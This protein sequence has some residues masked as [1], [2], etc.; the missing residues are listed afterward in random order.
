MID[1]TTGGEIPRE[2]INLTPK[3]LLNGFPKAGL[4]FA[5]LMLRPVAAEMPAGQMHARPFVGTFAGHS[6]TTEWTDVPRFMYHVS[7]LQPGRYFYSHIGHSD[8]IEAF[9]YYLGAS[10]L[11]CS[12]D[13]RD[14]AVS[15]AHH[16]TADNEAWSHPDKDLYRD[17][18][19]FDEAL[20]A[21]IVGID[22]YPGVVERWEAYAG[23]WEADWVYQ[24]R[25]EDAI[26]DPFRVARAI[27]TYGIDRMATLFGYDLKGEGPKL[28]R[29]AE[30]MVESAGQREKSLT[31]RKGQV[32]GWRDAFTEK[33]KRL[34]KE[35]DKHGWLIRLGYEQ[36]DQW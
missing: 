28:D 34:F 16:A 25:F 10:V 24:F 19:G 2:H 20:E 30:A 22:R 8:N 14:V 31:F 9:C 18:G 23:W 4:H 12:R 35:S 5:E 26:R 13:L 3:W 11:F 7:R 6:W 36:D 17:L 33:H 32:G 21:C 15:H 29:I 1:P 27:L